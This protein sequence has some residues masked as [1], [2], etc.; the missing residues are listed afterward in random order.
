MGIFY[1]VLKKVSRFMEGIAGFALVAMMLLTVGDVVLRCFDRPIIGTYELVSFMGAVVIGF[2]LPIQ[3]LVR[4]HIWVDMLFTKLNHNNKARLQVFTRMV[5]A[6]LTFSLG[7]NFIQMALTMREAGEVSLTLQLPVYPIA[8]G[9]GV[10]CI[11]VCL[12][13]VSDIVKIFGGI[14]DE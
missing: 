2:T 12:I 13:L 9:L 4:G 10:A 7:W 8:M 14:Y 6:A 11:V 1:D 5:S 3:T